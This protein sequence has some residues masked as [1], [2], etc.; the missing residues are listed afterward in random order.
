MIKP[1]RIPIQSSFYIFHCKDCEYFFITEEIN[2]GSISPCSLCL[3]YNVSRIKIETALNGLVVMIQKLKKSQSA[4]IK[5][6]NRLL[7]LDSDRLS[8]DNLE[9]L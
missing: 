8:D 7:L 9:E 6:I 4:A 3:K 5:E 2:V 1:L